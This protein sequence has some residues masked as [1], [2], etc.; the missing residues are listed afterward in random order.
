MCALAGGRSIESTMGFTALDGLPMG[1]R[2]GQI[3]PGVVLYLIEQKGMSAAEVQKLFYH[4]SGLKG[5]SGLSNDVRELAASS[6][7]AAEFA[8]DYFC[9][10]AGL[11]TG[12]LAAALGGV[13]AFVFTAGIGENSESM[14]MRTGGKCRACASHIWS[15]E[16]DRDVCDSDRRG[17]DDRAPHAGAAAGERITTARSGLI[18]CRAGYVM[19]RGPPGSGRPGRCSR[20][21]PH[22]LCIP[23]RHVGGKERALRGRHARPSS[24]LIHTSFLGLAWA[25]RSG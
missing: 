21:M 23:A 4:E 25:P 24:R 7:P 17:I 12:M 14:R 8:L 18:I 22:C 10:R 19:V 15:E 6:N 1:T 13:D 9:Y 5:L 3:D 16:P 20:A 2:P 11:Y